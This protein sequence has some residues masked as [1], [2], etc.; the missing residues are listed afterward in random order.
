ML[1][2]NTGVVQAFFGDPQKLYGFVTDN[3][4]DARVHFHWDRGRRIER[5]PNTNRVK[6]VGSE[7]LRDPIE[8]DELVF[9]RVKTDRGYA[10]RFWA[11]NSEIVDQGM[12]I[13]EEESAGAPALPAV[14]TCRV[15]VETLGDDNQSIDFYVEWEGSPDAIPQ[16]YWSPSMKGLVFTYKGT[17]FRKKLQQLDW[18]DVD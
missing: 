17:R 11:F 3:K 6:V 9:L 10:V 18:H 2:R 4:D 12:P 1:R 15:L 16:P 7:A 13:E 8:G 14:G 5:I